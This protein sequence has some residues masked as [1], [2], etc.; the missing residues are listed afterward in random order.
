MDDRTAGDA[1]PSFSFLVLG[2]PHVTLIIE[3]RLALISYQDH[4][5]RLLTLAGL[6]AMNLHTDTQHVG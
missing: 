1:G 6:V 4:H 3:L 2:L 5:I